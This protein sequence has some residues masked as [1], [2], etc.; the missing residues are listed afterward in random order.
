MSNIP[1]QEIL[2]QALDGDVLTS[3]IRDETYTFYPSDG[4]PEINIRSGELTRWLHDK[5]QS[6]VTDLTFPEE[7]L[8]EIID[9]NGVHVP[10]ADALTEEQASMPVVV[11]LWHDGSGILIDGAHRRHYWAKRGITTIRGW[12]VPEEVWRHYVFDP[13]QMAGIVH[14]RD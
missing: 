3:L 9:R 12:A 6:K 10:R 14:D 11:G 13:A 2:A 1:Q 7:T 4:S 8:E 5:A